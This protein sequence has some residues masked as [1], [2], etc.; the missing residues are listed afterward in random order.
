VSVQYRIS[1]LA[2]VEQAPEDGSVWHA[3]CQR[4]MLTLPIVARFNRQRRDIRSRGFGQYYPSDAMSAT[5]AGAS[6]G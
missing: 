4:V 2:L 1:L 3:A 5:A 6:D